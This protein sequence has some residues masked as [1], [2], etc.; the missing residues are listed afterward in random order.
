MYNIWDTIYYQ[1]NNKF[2]KW[3]IQNICT[4]HYHIEKWL[5]VY[6]KQIFEKPFKEWIIKE[7]DKLNKEIEILKE[8][9]V[10]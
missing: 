4:G 8:M 1:Y 9:L 10:L 7:L 5:I 6:P 3:V 2:Y